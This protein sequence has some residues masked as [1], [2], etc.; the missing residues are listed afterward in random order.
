M[1]SLSLAISFPNEL[2]L[3]IYTVS[4]FVKSELLHLYF[5]SAIS[6]VKILF[7]YKTLVVQLFTV[8]TFRLLTSKKFIIKPNISLLYTSQE[9]S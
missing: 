9:F 3:P 2:K 5:L 1:I 8:N 4:T 6:V 7:I